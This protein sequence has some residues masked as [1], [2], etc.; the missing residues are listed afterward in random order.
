[1]DSLQFGVQ[2]SLGDLVKTLRDDDLRFDFSQRTAGIM[3]IMTKFAP[4]EVCLPLRDIAGN[5]NGSPTYLVG[6]AV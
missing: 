2:L 6:Q 3:Q 5:R 4:A 1:M